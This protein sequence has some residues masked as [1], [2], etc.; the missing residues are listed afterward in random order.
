MFGLLPVHAEAV[1]WATAIPESLAG[2]LQ[3]GSFY[4]YLRYREGHRGNSLA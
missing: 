4:F 2:T 3:L 1:I